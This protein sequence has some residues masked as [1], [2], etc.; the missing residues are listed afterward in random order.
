M[1][2]DAIADMVAFHDPAH[3]N[4]VTPLCAGRGADVLRRKHR[5]GHGPDQ[6]Q[7]LVDD[8]RHAVQ[9]RHQRAVVLRGGSIDCR[10]L[11]QHLAVEHVVHPAQGMAFQ[12]GCG[13]GKVSLG[14][15]RILPDHVAIFANVQGNHALVIGCPGD[16]LGVA[17]HIHAQLLQDRGGIGHHPFA[18]DLV[19][20]D[21]AVGNGARG[22][23]ATGGWPQVPVLGMA[24]GTRHQMRGVKAIAVIAGPDH[25]GRHA[26]PFGKGYKPL[27]GVAHHLFT[28]IDRAGGAIQHAVMG[29][30]AVDQA[31]IALVPDTVG[32]AHDVIDDIG[33]DVVKP[34]QRLG[35]RAVA[36]RQVGVVVP[37]DL[38]H[39]LDPLCSNLALGFAVLCAVRHAER[40]CYVWVPA[41]T[42]GARPCP[43]L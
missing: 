40:S 3:R 27:D 33:V 6:A 28:G 14:L 10:D 39:R 37:F 25:M 32:T 9:F 36:G 22:K 12:I 30:V 5:V 38:H 26:T 19:F 23:S 17:L 21:H 24:P 8:C 42:R 7:R 18:V 20:K 16:A 35:A 43:A 34:L 13:D 1:V 41:A 31:D 11:A 2:Q 15:G 29:V 4:L